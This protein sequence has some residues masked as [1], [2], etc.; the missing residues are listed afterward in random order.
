MIPKLS[1]F[2]EVDLTP[3]IDGIPVKKLIDLKKT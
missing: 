3:S 2:R 1:V